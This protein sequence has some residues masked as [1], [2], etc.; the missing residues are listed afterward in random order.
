MDDATLRRELQALRAR[1]G[2]T[3]WQDLDRLLKAVGAEC[4]RGRGD[5]R[6]YRH[7]AWRRPL[8]IDSRR[9]HVLPVYVRETISRIE[10]VLDR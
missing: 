6:V 8:T 2:S 4:R 5:H 9:P 3:R 10:E 7:P 1:Q